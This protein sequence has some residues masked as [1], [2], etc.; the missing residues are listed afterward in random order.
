MF[1]LSSARRL[2]LALLIS[3]A[4]FRGAEARADT[5][6]SKPAKTA[7]VPKAAADKAA[8]DKAAADKVALEKAAAD[9]A[10]AERAACR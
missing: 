7:A 10:A 1:H 4:A 3:A 9:K 2:A 5:P 6:P 8:A